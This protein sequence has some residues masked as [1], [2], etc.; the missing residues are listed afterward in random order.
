MAGGS[1]TRGGG[2]SPRGGRGGRSGGCQGSPPP[3][4]GVPSTETQ[5]SPDG[6]G[7]Q[8]G[9]LPPTP[10]LTA[11]DRADAEQR[12]R[13]IT[14]LPV[15]PVRTGGNKR[16]VEGRAWRGQGRQ[17]A[18]LSSPGCR[19]GQQTSGGVPTF[20]ERG[21]ISWGTEWMIG[22]EHGTLHGCL[23]SS[24]GRVLE[25][26]LGGGCGEHE[27]EEAPPRE[28]REG[29]TGGEGLLDPGP[30]PHSPKRPDPEATRPASQPRGRTRR[31]LP[32]SH[33]RPWL[34]PTQHR[35]AS[36]PLSPD[37]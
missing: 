5:V 18:A 1:V 30:T 17:R 25:M 4:S 32:E 23:Q 31:N 8:S 22:G 33:R 13:L 16:R 34:P 27:S 35:L 9:S 29:A 14:S 7:G 24:E 20:L 12:P 28:I 10:A 19:Q 3:K 36:P 11:E 15:H 37:P 6:S 21:D 2:G 26:W